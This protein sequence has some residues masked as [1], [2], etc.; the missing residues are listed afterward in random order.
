MRARF[1]SVLELLYS[2][3]SGRLSLFPLKL[4]KV[5]KQQMSKGHDRMELGGSGEG[6]AERQIR[7]QFRKPERERACRCP[8]ERG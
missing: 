6:W 3:E 5:Q 4:G 1:Y 7:K 8:S 2:E